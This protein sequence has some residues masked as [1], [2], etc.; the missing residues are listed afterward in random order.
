EALQ[1]LGLIRAETELPSLALSSLTEIAARETDLPRPE[2]AP[3]PQL[4]AALQPDSLSAGSHQSLIDCPYQFFAASG[5][6]LRAPDEPDEPAGRRDFG[7][8]VHLI[9]QAFHHQMPGLP[10]PFSGPVT[11]V[12]R[13]A[14][15]AKLSE[16]AHAAF[17]PDLR[18]RALA[19]TWLTEFL[20]LVPELAIWLASRGTAWP[21]V[22]TEL[23]LGHEIAP[24]LHLHGRIDR[25]ERAADSE[26][27]VVDY[28]SGEAP[29]TADVENGEAVQA[30]HYALIAENCTRVEY[31][32]I[33]RDAKQSEPVEGEELA[34]ARRGVRKRLLDIFSALREG[35]ALPAQG[36]EKTC[37]YCNYAG[38]CRLGAWHE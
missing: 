18:Q 14:V 8:R 27:C 21:H 6:G 20:D 16:L 35:A 26:Q 2:T 22:S 37:G 10:P 5:L 25:L 19:K 9:M 36:D 28:K 23:K 34:E 7:E 17:A 13:L 32:V 1:A 33:K 3:R 4:D 11:P 30:T 31:L 12:Q 38:L 15:E 29:K 24:G